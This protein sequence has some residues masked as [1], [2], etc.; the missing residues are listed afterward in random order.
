VAVL[1]LSITRQSSAKCGRAWGLTSAFGD[2]DRLREMMHACE[3]VCDI[4]T[5]HLLIM[6]AITWR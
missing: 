5:Q 1:L 3:H 6:K 4:Y 2:M